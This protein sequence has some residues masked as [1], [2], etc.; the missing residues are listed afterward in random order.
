MHQTLV[1]R[2]KKEY[3]YNPEKA[4]SGPG[5]PYKDQA[6]IAELERMAGKL[7]A[8]KMFLKKPWT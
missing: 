5:H 7:Y 1:A 8:E 4:F 3:I 2:W 6:R